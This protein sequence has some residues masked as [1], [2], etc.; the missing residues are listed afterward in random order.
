MGLTWEKMLSLDRQP[1][2]E[3]RAARIVEAAAD[4]QVAA[5]QGDDAVD[6]GQPQAAALHAAR[7]GAAIQLLE[8]FAQ[9]L[10]QDT[11]ARIR[12]FDDDET[13][14]HPRAQFH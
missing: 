14:L 9:I 11:H 2:G 3:D 13:S 10:G 1:H 4:G 5:V 12:H 8:D 7:V 6:Q